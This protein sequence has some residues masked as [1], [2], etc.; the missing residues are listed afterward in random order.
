MAVRYKEAYSD[1]DKR[2]GSIR[3]REIK[4]LDQPNNNVKPDL[5][6]HKLKLIDCPTPNFYQLFEERV[7]SRKESKG[8]DR[9]GC[10]NAL[11]KRSRLLKRLKDYF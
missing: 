2:R 6:D 1:A 4:A 8:V 7:Q 11:N 10:K 9:N 5:L 3:P